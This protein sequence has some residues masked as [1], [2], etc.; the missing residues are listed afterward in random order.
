M[1]RWTVFI[2]KIRR[3][4]G[5][6]VLQRKWRNTIGRSSTRVLMIR[7]AFPLWLER[8]SSFCYRL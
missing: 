8:Q 6:Q 7:R 1:L 2:N 5:T 4:Q 3:L